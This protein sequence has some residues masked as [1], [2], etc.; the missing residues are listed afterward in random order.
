MPDDPK[1]KSPQDAERIDLNQPDEVHYWCVEFKCSEQELREAAGKVGN[2]VDG[3][4]IYFAN[5][6]LGR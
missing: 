4:R 3:L 6:H 5:L 1:K 2:S